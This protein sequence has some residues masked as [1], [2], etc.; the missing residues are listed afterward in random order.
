MC[1]LRGDG[2]GRG[3]KKESLRN[4]NKSLSIELQAAFLVVRMRGEKVE[5]FNM[6]DISTKYDEREI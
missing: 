5:T 3:I 6:V 4:L 1:G 2:K